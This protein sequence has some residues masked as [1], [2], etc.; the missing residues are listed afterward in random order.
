MTSYTETLTV[1]R[2]MKKGFFGIS[3][4]W[5]RRN[6]RNQQNRRN[7]RNERNQRKHARSMKYTHEKSINSLIIIL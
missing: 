4:S 2:S 5:N 7:Q 1:K 3:K 6:Q